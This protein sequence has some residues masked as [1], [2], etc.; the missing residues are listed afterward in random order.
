MIEKVDIERFMDSII[1]KNDSIYRNQI[2]KM[3]L[4]LKFI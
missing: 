4:C 3:N 2:D 1:E